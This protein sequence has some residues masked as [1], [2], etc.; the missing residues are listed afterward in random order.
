[1]HE[2]EEIVGSFQVI[3]QA[4]GKMVDGSVNHAGASRAAAGRVLAIRRS[5]RHVQL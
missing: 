5:R 4:T 2:V 3:V 1:M